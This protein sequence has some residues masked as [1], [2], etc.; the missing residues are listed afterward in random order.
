[1]ELKKCPGRLFLKIECEFNLPG[2]NLLNTEL[3]QLRQESSPRDHAHIV[4]KLY[5]DNRG[6]TW[7]GY[8]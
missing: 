3:Q 4:P 6:P 8:L 1:M 5:A 2:G 7:H